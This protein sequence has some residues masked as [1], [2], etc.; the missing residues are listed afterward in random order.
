MAE[1][2]G[3]FLVGISQHRRSF[4]KALKVRPREGPC[5]QL[6]RGGRA[7]E[8]NPSPQRGKWRLA[9]ARDFRG[10]EDLLDQGLRPWR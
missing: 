7:C 5:R 10:T 9:V 4:F 2:T 3:M 1:K 8:R 6:E